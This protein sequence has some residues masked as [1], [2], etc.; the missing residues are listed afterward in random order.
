MEHTNG[1]ADANNVSRSKSQQVRSFNQSTKQMCALC[2]LVTWLVL[3]YI[4]RGYEHLVDRQPAFAASISS[5]HARSFR[6]VCRLLSAAQA[7]KFHMYIL[8]CVAAEQPIRVP[9]VDAASWRAADAAPFPNQ[10]AAHISSL[11]FA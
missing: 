2:M 4:S 10:H 1:L 8:M 9:K 5:N 3:A 6:K 7:D 11:L